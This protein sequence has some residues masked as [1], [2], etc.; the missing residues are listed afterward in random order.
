M[1]SIQRYY[2]EEPMK[3]PNHC[4]EESYRQGILPADWKCANISNIFKKGSKSDASNY[5]GVS[6]TSVPVSSRECQFY[7]LNSEFAFLSHLFGGLEVTDAIHLQLDGKPIVDYLSLRI[8]ISQA[9]ALIRRNQLLLKGCVI[10]R[11]NMKFKGYTN[12]YMPL[13]RVMVLLQLCC[14]KFSHK[15]TL[16]QILFD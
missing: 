16:Q 6:L 11:L 8:A 14:W 15:E 13:D 1:K 10:L 4:L 9:E 7:P 2:C 12:L 5:R 3:Q